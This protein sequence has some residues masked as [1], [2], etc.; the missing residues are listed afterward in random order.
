M[1]DSAVNVCM[2]GNIVKRLEWRL[3]RKALYKCSPFTVYWY[4]KRPANMSPL[5]PA[6][7]DVGSG[8]SDQETQAVCGVRPWLIEHLQVSGG[9]LAPGLSV[10]ETTVC[11]R[12]PVPPPTV[13]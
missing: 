2:N 10:S 4:N 1:V 8:R 9:D 6:R 13:R 11:K 3:V 7:Y 5:L 12:C